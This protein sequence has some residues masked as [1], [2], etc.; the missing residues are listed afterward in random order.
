MPAFQSLD[1]SSRQDMH[2]VIVGGG[3]V[4]ITLALGLT[5]QKISVRVYEQAAGFREVGAGIAFSECARRCSAYNT[6]TLCYF[7]LPI[8]FLPPHSLRLP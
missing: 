4:G 3:I 8:I 5:R 1:G 2:I 6:I 7:C